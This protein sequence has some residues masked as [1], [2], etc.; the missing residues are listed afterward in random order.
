MNAEFQTLTTDQQAAVRRVIDQARQNG[1]RQTLNLPDGSD[2][3]VM[4]LS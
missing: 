3:N 4:P 1:E 2:A